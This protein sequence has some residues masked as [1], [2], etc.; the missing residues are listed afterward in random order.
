MDK[1]EELQVALRWKNEL[2]TKLDDL[3]DCLSEILGSI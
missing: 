2:E 3:K 1:E